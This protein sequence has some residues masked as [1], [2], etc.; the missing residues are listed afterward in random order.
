[1]VVSSLN[2][3]QNY[4]KIDSY[5]SRS[6]QVS[7]EDIL[8]LKS[9]GVTDIINFRTMHA[10]NIGFDEKAFVESNGIKY[11][12]IPSVSSSP[13]RIN[14]EKFLDIVNSI[15]NKN[16]KVHIHCRQGANR[17]GMY[18]YIYERLNKIGT[19]FDNYKEFV[20]R[21]WHFQKYP[22]I[23]LWA[24]RLVANILRR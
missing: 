20:K 17:T 24:E 22:H 19:P 10:P 21:G 9:Q 23:A 18:S 13:K 12:S 5:L 16:G 2:Y 15:K 3:P 11:H 1:M 6:A 7:R 4:H 8:W 14:V